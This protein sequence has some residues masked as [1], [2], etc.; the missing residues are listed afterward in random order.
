M[1]ADKITT[2]SPTYATEILRP[3]NSFGL[4]GVLQKRVGDIFGILNGVDTDVWNPATDEA[5]A[6]QYGPSSLASKAQCKTAL[7]KEAGLKVQNDAPLLC[8]VSRLAVQK[9][10]DIVLD[11]LPEILGMG[12]Q[13]I[14]LG[15]G[16]VSVESAFRNIAYAYPQSVSIHATYDELKSH[17]V[18][19][20]SDIILLPS[21]Y[22]PC[23]LTQLYGL[24][25]GT[26]P[27]VHRV[28][29]L[30]DTVVNSSAE[31]IQAGTATGF[32]FDGF[33]Y[34]AFMGS[35]RHAF[36]LFKRKKEWQQIQ[37]NA[38]RQ[39][40]TWEAAAKRYLTL[41]EQVHRSR[42]ASS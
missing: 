42:G 11:G 9:G 6:I 2:V 22:E 20:G 12:G 26:L 14:V 4:N 29:G 5:I 15:T 25:Y 40:F 8:I 13:L 31:N 30:A 33:Y 27:L 28:G 18:I 21:R 19:A 17:R 34:E 36:D 23:G 39:Q 1:Y 37:L 16:D 3:E 38:M 7:Q 24:R 41:Y 10:L 35:V 32:T